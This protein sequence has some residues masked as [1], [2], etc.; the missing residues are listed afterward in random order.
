MHHK[1]DDYLRTLRSEA[2][3]GKSGDSASGSKS[4]KGASAKRRDVPQLGQQA[5]QSI[6]PLKVLSRD[7]PVQ[8]ENQDMAEAA[9]L[10][11]AM[12]VT[13]ACTSHAISAFVLAVV[14]T[15]LC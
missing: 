7:V 9:K 1:L 3:K 12:G 5:K 11:A 10:A 15:S 13:L 6:P 8:A 14:A 2:R 4:S